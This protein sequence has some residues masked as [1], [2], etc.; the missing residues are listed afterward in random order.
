MTQLRCCTHCARHVLIH[1]RACPFCQR[2]LPPAAERAP[3]KIAAG[4]SRAQRLALAAAIAGQSV[5]ACA[6]TSEPIPQSMPHYGAPLAGNLAPAAGSGGAGQQVAG[7]S[8][9]AGTTGVAVPVY[10]APVYGAPIA[11]QPSPKPK[12]DAGVPDVDASDE[13]AGGVK[14]AGHVV[15][16]VY[17]APIPIYGAPTPRR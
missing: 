16:P 15:Q 10:G 5:A 13:D 14:D 3:V 9:A 4:L 17:G 8:G 2:D 1:E 6:E 7:R 11:G 12:P